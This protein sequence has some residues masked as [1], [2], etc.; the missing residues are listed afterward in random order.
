M[1]LMKRSVAAAALA[2]AVLTGCKKEQP[3]PPPVAEAIPT[4]ELRYVTL[5]SAIGADKLVTAAKEAFGVRDTIYASVSTTGAG[6]NVK[7]KALWTFGAETVRAD[8]LILNLVGATVSEFHITR[9]RAWPVGAYRVSV[10]LNDG[11]PQ[12]RDFTVR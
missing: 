10:T 9:P 8:S 5:G 11:A 4:P 1:H 7:L 12:T 6:E 2:A 3:P